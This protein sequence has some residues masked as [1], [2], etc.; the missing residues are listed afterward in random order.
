MQRAVIKQ[1]KK[2][3]Q[4]SGQL[5]VQT[6]PNDVI[7]SFLLFKDFYQNDLYKYFKIYVNFRY[8]KQFA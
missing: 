3:T 4:C 2:K 1:K 7:C 8:A 5:I 6:G